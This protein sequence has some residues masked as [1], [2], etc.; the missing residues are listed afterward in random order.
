MDLTLVYINHPRKIQ[1]NT[2][3]GAGIFENWSTA[4]VI[5]ITPISRETI[6]KLGLKSRLI[7]SLI[8]NKVAPDINPTTAALIPSNE[9]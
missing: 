2:M 5:T 3:N 6:K 7:M 4:N 8:K 1:A 9:R